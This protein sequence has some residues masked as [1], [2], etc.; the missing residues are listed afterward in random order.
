MNTN[1]DRTSF[2]RNPK[3]RVILISSG[4][5][6]VVGLLAFFAY[7]N[8]TF[9]NK[10]SEESTL[11]MQSVLDT[12]QVE[13]YFRDDFKRRDL[14]RQFAEFYTDRDYRLAWSTLKK[15]LPLADSLFNALQG[16]SRE[17]LQ[18]DDYNLAEL[19]QM[20]DSVFQRSLLKIKYKRPDLLRLVQLDFQ[21]TAAYLTYASHLNTGRINPHKVDET[22]MINPQRNADLAKNL[23]KALKSR[24]VNKALLDLVPRR[25][26][27]RELREQLVRYQQIEQQGGWPAVEASPS[28]RP[29]QSGA[30]VAALR[31]RL[32]LT[33]DLPDGGGADSTLFDDALVQALK[34]FQERHGLNPS[35]KVDEA[36]LGALNV[37][38]SRRISQINLNL[39]R[40]RWLPDDLG[41]EYLM[42]NVPAFDLKIMKNNRQDLRM[43]VVVGKE[44]NLT[45][46]FRDTMEY[47]VFSPDWT[48]PR[49]IATKEILPIAQRNPD[50][51]LT[52]NYQVYDSWDARDTMAL[53]P[54][55]IDWDSL[56]EDNFSYRVVQ[57]PGEGNALGAVKF[58]FPNKMDIYL[59]DTP[60]D[61]LFKRTERAFSHGCVRVEKPKELAEY[62]L[63]D[64]GK[65]NEES[66]TEAM[67][68]DKPENVKL[69]RKMPVYLVYF[70]AYIDENDR[71]NFRDDVYGHD[72]KQL[73]AL[74][75]KS[76]RL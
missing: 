52:H 18:P 4:I 49:S 59:H 28:Y 19:K 66:I 41:K 43:R 62:L 65:W 63:R 46:I 26:D 33:G 9:Q 13:A 75:K 3:N 64:S 76:A 58:M 16:A 54:L 10:R 14:H 5:V 32:A 50:Y 68:Q 21:L 42:V 72:A 2:W 27:Y 45:P 11:V 55:T 8:A 31:K 35:G 69:P 67:Q 1:T 12:L 22:W 47:I 60:A 39:E 17:G 38:V 73:S 53:D 15:P 57:G 70:T 30:G 48:V 25:D 29:G 34:G 74:V 51:L 44:L 71:L 7:R 20:R 40:M 56:S 61:H 23:E 37:P 24:H 36:T 6:L